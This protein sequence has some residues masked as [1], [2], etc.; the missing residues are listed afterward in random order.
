VEGS[1]KRIEQYMRLR[2]EGWHLSARAFRAESA[3][4]ARQA[5]EL[6]AKAAALASTATPA[7]TSQRGVT[8]R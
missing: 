8:P 7:D 5:S 2:G 6:F 3:V 1:R 4:L